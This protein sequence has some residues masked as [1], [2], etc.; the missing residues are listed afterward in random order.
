SI[1]SAR[2]T[3]ANWRPAA[4]IEPPTISAI[5]PTTIL[6]DTPSAPVGFTIGDPDTAAVSLTVKA[7]SSN[8]AVVP[9]TPAAL[10]LAGSRPGGPPPTS[11][12]PRSPPSA[13]RRTGKT[14]RAHL[15]GSRLAIRRRPPSA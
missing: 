6:E 15:P 9:N 10:A 3:I 2:V 4:D 11:H 1:N 7:A 13:R 5:G 14:R 12:R 8:P